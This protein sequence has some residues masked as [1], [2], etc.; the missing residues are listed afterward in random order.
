MATET[1]ATVKKF[2]AVVIGSGQSGT[3]LA[4]ALA[5]AGRKTALIE[6]TH[7]QGCC[8]NEGC[9][10]TK[11][12]ISSGR[13]AHLGRRAED[14][15][16]WNVPTQN[17]EKGHKA[18]HGRVEG[19]WEKVNVAIDMQ[20]VRQRKRD[21]VDSF[22]GGSEG[23]LKKQEGLE[24]IMGEAS[25]KDAHSLTVK[26]A[27]GGDD[28]EIEAETI[29]INTGERPS[30]P[31]L[32]GLDSLDQKRVLNST[33]I[34]ELG[35]VPHHLIILGGGYI[36]LE[37]GQLFRR[38]GS[39]VTIIQRG[40]QLM[41]REDPEIAEAVQEIIESE[42]TH[43]LLNTKVA[44]IKR[45]DCGDFEKKVIVFYHNKQGRDVALSGSHLLLATGRTPNTDM[46]NLSAAGVEFDSRGSVKVDSKLQTAA[47]HIY[48]MGDVHGGPA[49]THIS[50]DDFRILRANVIEKSPTPHSTTDRQV[51]YVAYI[52]PQLGHIGL[53]EQEARA[54]YPD[55][56]IQTASMPMAYVARAL[57]TDETRGLMKA[58]V[59]GE[60]EQIL[61]FTCLGIEGGELV[62][63]VQM[64]MLGKL[65]YKVL[66]TAVLAHPSLAESLN[67]LW[68]Y[69]K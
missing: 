18:F 24:V 37:F 16:I 41:P 35:E 20:K 45:D 15:G 50:Y 51:P 31:Q 44:N 64:A 11:T 22:R 63:V 62:A 13:V 36:G 1:E 7:I 4:S 6:K 57:E 32:P 14:Y 60:T 52:D 29:F 68:G 21:I 61:G 69:L 3:P 59:N 17:L 2:D 5:Q 27:E 34:M 19:G 47:S 49:F 26:L 58:V 66:Q 42:G 33:S 43:V 12:M 25:F 8:V 56:K 40:K 39:R 38:L 9:T 10:P 46:L 54:Q 23:R 30:R 53:H 67:N 65:S 55:A 28:I 48:A